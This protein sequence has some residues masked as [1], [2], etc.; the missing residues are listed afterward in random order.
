[1][2]GQEKRYIFH[3]VFLQFIQKM[4][5]FLL[6]LIILTEEVKTAFYHESGQFVSQLLDFLLLGVVD[7]VDFT[8]CRL[9]LLLKCLNDPLFKTGLFLLGEAGKFL[10]RYRA[11][12]PLMGMV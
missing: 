2:R 10:L 9:D 4:Q 12:S 3:H 11:P 1:L 7:P 5:K 8:H 6:I